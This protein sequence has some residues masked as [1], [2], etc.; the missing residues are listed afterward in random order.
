MEKILEHIGGTKLKSIPRTGNKLAWL[1]S[2]NGAGPMGVKIY[3]TWEGMGVRTS[4]L[5]T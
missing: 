4:G 3:E 5:A 1:Q 2:V